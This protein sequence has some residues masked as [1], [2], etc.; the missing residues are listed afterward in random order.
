M[1][2]HQEPKALPKPLK[3]PSQ[4]RA[5]FTVQALYDAFVRIW[6]RD[7][8]KAA[9]TKAVAAEAGFAVGTVYDYFPNREA[10]FSGYVRH[11][12]EL[13]LA[14]IDAQVI[15]AG[16]L[17]WDERLARLVRIT[18]CVDRDAAYFDAAMLAREH[19][20]A[21]PKHHRRFF[22]ELTAKWTEAVRSWSD[23]TPQPPD[24]TIRALCVATWGAR[25][26]VL[27]VGPPAE[28][29]GD[30]VTEL[31]RVARQALRTPPD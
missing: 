11:S 7:G 24:L 21:E 22:D 12:L 13:L 10:L 4:A 19:E 2:R 29:L 16:G 8:P 14:R 25:R 5:K 6:R 20:V 18:A 15:A 31:E 27:L 17:A 1:S 3:R 30:W 9:N 28:A 26:Y 23:L